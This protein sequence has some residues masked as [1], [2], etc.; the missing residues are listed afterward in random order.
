MEPP[1]IDS[2]RGRF[3]DFAKTAASLGVR[4]L[5][6]CE[7]AVTATG[8]DARVNLFFSHEDFPGVRFGYRCLE[9][10]DD[11]YEEVWLCEELA[12]GAL[13]RMM[14]YDAPVPA[15]DGIVWTRLHGQLLGADDENVT[16]QLRLRAVVQVMATGDGESCGIFASG[17]H[18][19]PEPCRASAVARVVAA[20]FTR[21]VVGADGHPLG[22]RAGLYVGACRDHLGELRRRARAHGGHLQD[23][24]GASLRE[25]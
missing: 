7:T 23:S 1:A 5:R 2:Q 17:G 13:H 11:P 12:T 10:G 20:T 16:A 4:G 14:G 6:D 24:S 8:A 25:P 15:E 18:R 22:D 9:P 19:E 21:G 3:D